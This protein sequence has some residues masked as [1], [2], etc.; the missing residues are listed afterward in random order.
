MTWVEQRNSNIHIAVLMRT[1]QV[2]LGYM[3]APNKRSQRKLLET[4][5]KMPFLSPSQQH[6]IKESSGYSSGKFLC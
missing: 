5:E 4:A 3:V 1:F 2:Y 6:R